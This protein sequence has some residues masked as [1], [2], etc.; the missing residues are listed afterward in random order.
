MNEKLF[1]G[2]VCL[3]AILAVAILPGAPLAAAE[4]ITLKLMYVALLLAITFGLI[5]VFR[6]TKWD[7]YTEIISQ[8]NI[9]GALFLAAIIISI[10][11]VIGK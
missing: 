3:L 8:H 2:L 1:A 5:H 9:A 10:A 7:F 6:G 11:M 4:I